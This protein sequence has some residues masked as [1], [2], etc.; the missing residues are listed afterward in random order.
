MGFKIQIHSVST[1]KWDIMIMLQS[2]GGEAAEKTS[3]EAAI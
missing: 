3:N 1:A 2:Y